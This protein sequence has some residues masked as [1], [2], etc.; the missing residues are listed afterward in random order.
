MINKI[1]LSFTILNY[2]AL[3]R[4]N[5]FTPFKSGFVRSKLN[6]SSKGLI[7]YFILQ[8]VNEGSMTTLAKHFESKSEY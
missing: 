7:G 5:S 1:Y 2:T 6:H 4:V 3:L 8:M